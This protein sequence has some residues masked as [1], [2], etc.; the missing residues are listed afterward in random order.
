MGC[1][2]VLP[3]TFPALTMH[4]V[5][6]LRAKEHLHS[7]KRD[8]E[9]EVGEASRALEPTLVESPAGPWPK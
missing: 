6:A 3:V 9:A 2:L 5:V 7:V 4:L 1:V 8:P